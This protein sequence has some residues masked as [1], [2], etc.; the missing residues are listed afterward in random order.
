VVIP[1]G[2]GGLIAG[3]AC[4]VKETNPKIQSDRRAILEARFDESGA[5]KKQARHAAR[6]QN[7]RGRHRRAL[8][9]DAHISAGPKI[10]GRNRDRGRGRNRQ[11][12]LQLLEKEKML[13]E[14]AGAAATAA[15]LNKKTPNHGK[16]LGVLVSA[17]NIDVSLLSLI[18]ERG[19]VKDGR[20]VRLRIHLPDHPGALQRLAGV[21]ADQK[22]NIVETMYDRAYYGVVLG[23]TVIDITME[24]RGPEHVADLTA[25][26]EAGY[27]FE[28]VQ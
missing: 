28:R 10:R 16:K 7:H 3:V 13:A 5:R 24:T 11:R 15:V 20:L 2:G 25:A 26:L 1:V 17:G 21:I 22:A 6:E 12:D 19:L 9:G 23:D 27:P 8:R 18:I 4:A 14:G